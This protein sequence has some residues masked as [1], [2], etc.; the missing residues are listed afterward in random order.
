MISTRAS[1]IQELSE[2]DR[3][4]LRMGGIVRGMIADAVASFLNGEL[5]RVETVFGNDDLVD[6]LEAEVESTCLQLLALQQPMARDLRRVS[7]AIKVASELERMGDHAVLI[8]KY[9]RKLHMECFPLR[10]LIDL[11][12][13][14]AVAEQM[15]D[16]SLSAFIHHDIELVK[17]VCV[18]DDIVDAEYKDARRQLIE[19]AS[20]DSSNAAAA[21]YTI[22]VAGSIERI[23]DHATNIAERVAY[24]ETGV[25][26]RLSKA[27]RIPRDSD[28]P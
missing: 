22:L 19:L 14:S 6:S 1:F 10:P 20:Q 13:M 3:K 15:L 25:F 24:L 7:S 12:R 4:L 28:K 9:A 21:T 11:E 26:Q 2:V 27:H 18:D 8:V 16:D 5:N 23:A 17:S